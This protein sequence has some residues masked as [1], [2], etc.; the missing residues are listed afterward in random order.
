VK[1]ETVEHGAGEIVEENN[2]GKHNADDE[3]V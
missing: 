3:A 2:V 1:L